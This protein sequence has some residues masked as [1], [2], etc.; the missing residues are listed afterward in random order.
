[1][2]EAG[3]E[4]TMGKLD[5]IKSQVEALPADERAVATQSGAT[6]VGSGPG[7]IIAKHE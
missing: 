6:N 2:P 7:T 5:D 4:F 1:M 3:K